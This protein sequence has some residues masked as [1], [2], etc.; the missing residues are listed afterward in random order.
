MEGY[1]AGGIFG[2]EGAS[3]ASTPATS[4]LRGHSPQPSPSSLRLSG[5]RVQ[6]PL[7]GDAALCD[8]IFQK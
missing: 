1:V 7:S 5:S 8:S 2:G 6:S 3:P 4:S